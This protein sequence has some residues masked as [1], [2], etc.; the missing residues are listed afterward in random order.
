MS[1]DEASGRLHR[2]RKLNDRLRVDLLDGEWVLTPGIAALDNA[3]AL[4]VI[5]EVRTF[6]AFPSDNASSDEHDFGA[7]EVG[8][9]RLCWKID[10]YGL[11][12]RHGSPD[13]ADRAKTRRV[14]TVMLAEEFRGPVGRA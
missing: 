9:V 7:M 3:L 11:D 1:R 14:L 10:Y 5:H 8:G 2:I 13:P 6:D 12:K 4:R